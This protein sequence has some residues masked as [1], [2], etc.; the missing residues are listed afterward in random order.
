[1]NLCFELIVLSW[2][3]CPCTPLDMLFHV[4]TN[5]T[6]RYFC[7]IFIKLFTS[8]L[9]GLFFFLMKNNLKDTGIYFLVSVRKLAERLRQLSRGASNICWLLLFVHLS[10]VVVSF[11]SP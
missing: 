2:W 11:Y 3:L 4:S 8:V 10:T 6:C 7:F 5:S 9:F 1:M